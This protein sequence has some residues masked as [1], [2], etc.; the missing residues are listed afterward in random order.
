MRAMRNTVGVIA[1]LL[2]MSVAQGASAITPPAGT[3]DLSLM[4]LR[5]SDLPAGSTA[6]TAS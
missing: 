6:S 4:A 1:V 2:A 3:P 5:V